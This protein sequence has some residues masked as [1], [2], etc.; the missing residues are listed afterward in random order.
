MKKAIIII[1]VI[2]LAAL[3]GIAIFNSPYTYSVKILDSRAVTL[4]EREFFYDN[5]IANLT[6]YP[7]DYGFEG[8]RVDA[9]SS[10]PESRAIIVKTDEEYDE[11]FTDEADFRVDFDKKMLV[12]MS[13]R[14]TNNDAIHIL[15]T[16]PRNGTLYVKTWLKPKVLRTDASGGCI[17]YQRYVV[18][19]MNKLD[20]DN[21]EVEYVDN[22]L[23]SVRP[24]FDFLE[25]EF[26][27]R[28]EFPDT[29]S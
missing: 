23:Y 7:E 2:L 16:S 15:E 11:I 24:F 22:R 27:F 10:Y 6:Y 18:F 19:E 28:W 14:C 12:V 26:G 17:P 1:T 21:V 20:V 25:I 13:Y 3:I 9:S 8:E 29:P 5:L 4:I